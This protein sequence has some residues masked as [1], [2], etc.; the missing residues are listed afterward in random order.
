MNT[1]RT[2]GTV[3]RMTTLAETMEEEDKE[4]GVEE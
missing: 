1:L 4:V 2:E 3:G